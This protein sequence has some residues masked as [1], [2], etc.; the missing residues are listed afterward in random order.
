M[1]SVAAMKIPGTDRSRDS[2]RIAWR[3]ASPV[4][5]MTAART[6]AAISSQMIS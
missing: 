2:A 1:I 6:K 5:L 4:R 3:S